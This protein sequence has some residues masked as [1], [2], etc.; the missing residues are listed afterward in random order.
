MYSTPRQSMQRSVRWSGPLSLLR[1]SRRCVRELPADALHVRI[2]SLPH[3]PQALEY[4]RAEKF[5]YALFRRAGELG[6]LGVTVDPE[7]GGSGM[8]ATAACI[9]HEVRARPPPARGRYVPYAPIP[10]PERPEQ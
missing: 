2:V 8:D 9:V 4:N 10:F 6:L 7:Y 3:P 5:N 1:W